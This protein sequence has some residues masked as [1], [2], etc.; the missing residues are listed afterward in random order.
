[1][2]NKD[3]SM[4]KEGCKKCNKKG[5]RRLPRDDSTGLKEKEQDR[6][7]RIIQSIK[8]IYYNQNKEYKDDI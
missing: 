4:M 3:S 1:M 8:E 5:M 2:K 7:K 6:T